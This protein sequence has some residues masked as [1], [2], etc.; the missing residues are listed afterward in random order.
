RT[1]DGG[2]SWFQASNGRVMGSALAVAVDPLDRSHLLLATDSGLLGSRNGGRDWEL[3]AT[4]L[5]SGAVLTVAI[6][7]AGST[8]LAATA[9]AVGAS[10]DGVRWHSRL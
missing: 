2:T 6:D 1:A 3:I 7:R 5:L 10:D 4:D 8:L 9:S